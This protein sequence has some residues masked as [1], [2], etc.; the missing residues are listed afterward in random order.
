MK[1]EEITYQK[2]YVS[3]R[4]VPK[5]SYK[6]NW[7]CDLESEVARS[8]KDI[9]RIAPKPNT[10]LSSTVRPVWGKK[11]EIEE[12]TKFGRDTRN[13]EKHDEDTNSTSTGM[14]VS[15]HKSA[16]RYVLTPRHVENDQ[17]GT[18]NLVT[19]DQKEEHKIHFRVPG[20]SHSV[21]KEAEHL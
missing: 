14:P 12:R 2:V 9:Q 18:E 19:V 10:Q 3:P 21:V 4:L 11:E 15:R 1:S 20:L 6:D 5:M 8:S 16:K 13:Q 17:T 7:T